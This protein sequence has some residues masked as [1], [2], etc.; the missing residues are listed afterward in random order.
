MEVGRCHRRAALRLTFNIRLL[1]ALVP[2]V[3]SVRHMRYS[4][5]KPKIGDA[6]VKSFDL[7]SSA[8]NCLIP[9]ARI[10]W[11]PSDHLRLPVKQPIAIVFGTVH[12]LYQELLMLYVRGI[13]VTLKLSEELNKPYSCGLITYIRYL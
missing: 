6:K 2:T 5:I 8:N 12:G 9:H 11:A 4:C 10:W 3:H 7:P 13:L 1:F